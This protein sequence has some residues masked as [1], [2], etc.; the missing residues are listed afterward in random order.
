TM[1][2]GIQTYLNYIG[3]KWVPASTGEVEASI[4]PANR[5]DVVGYVQLSG[6]DDLEKAVAAAKNALSFWRKRSGPE[7]GEFL[8]RMA[9]ILERSEERRVGKEGRS[10]GWR[11]RHH[12][13]QTNL[14]GNA[15][16][17]QHKGVC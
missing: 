6:R 10:R 14:R 16:R 12:T 8:H 13:A 15:W 4:N 11:H 1:T 9:N 17:Q 3:G 5:H 7:R 2:T